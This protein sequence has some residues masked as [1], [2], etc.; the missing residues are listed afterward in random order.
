MPFNGTDLINDPMDTVASPFTDLLGSAFW[1]L[2]VGFIA[3][4]LYIKTRNFTA[5]SIWILGACAMLGT[6]NLFVDNPEMSFLY[7]VLAII[8][9][10]GT[11]A[12][13]YFMKK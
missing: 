5:S 8:G 9:F 3:V 6:S 1:L 2:P 4:A 13:I 10:T 7:Y 11:V 12:S